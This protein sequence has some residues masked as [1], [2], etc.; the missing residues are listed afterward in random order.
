MSQERKVASIFTCTATL[1]EGRQITIN[2]NFYDEDSA[3]ERDRRLDGIMDVL[4]RQRT[5]FEIP[6]MEAELMA[7]MKRL[8]DT[9]M[10]IKGQ[11]KEIERLNAEAAGHSTRAEAIKK[12]TAQRK[13]A[14]TSARQV[15]G[16]INTAKSNLSVLETNVE[17]IKKDIAEGVSKLSKMRETVAA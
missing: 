9:Y 4:E 3:V 17:M 12:G 16:S 7:R 15:E 2:G 13:M 8:E 10:A 6:S 11:M 5:R 14:E 1:I